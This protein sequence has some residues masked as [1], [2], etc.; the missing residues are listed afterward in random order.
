LTYGEPNL[1][2]QII[3]PAFEQQ[4]VLQWA[5][6]LEQYSKHPLAQPLIIA[7]QQANLK[8]LP[9]EQ[10][11]ELPGQ[12]LIGQ[13]AQHQLRITHRKQLLKEQPHLQDSLPASVGGLE[14]MALVDGQLAAIFRFRDQAR[15]EGPALV[16]HWGRVHHINRLLMISGDRREEVEYLAQQVGITELFAGQTP[17]QK[18]AIVTAETTKCKTIYVGDGINDAPAMLASSVGIAMGQRSEVTSAAAGAI[19]L[20]NHL[21]K[22]DELL[23][24]GMRMKRIAL[25]SALGGMALSLLG[26]GFAACG[27]LTPV[28]GAVLQEL[29]DVL[30]VLN[31]LR[32]AVPP[33]E[34][35]DFHG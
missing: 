33:R 17:E 2:E 34:I 28:A 5:A 27:Y 3:L 32:A 15:T 29:I 35:S 1:V 16:K 14:C 7:A 21:A 18:L 11:S 31:A 13:V 9:A 20:D 22:V 26:M 24:I 25:Q 30:A 4:P 6:S 23:H 10:V 19:I 8:L 12:G